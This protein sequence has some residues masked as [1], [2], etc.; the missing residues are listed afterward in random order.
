MLLST[1]GDAKSQLTQG[2]TYLKMKREVYYVLMIQTQW[3]Q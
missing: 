1:S 3:A 2:G